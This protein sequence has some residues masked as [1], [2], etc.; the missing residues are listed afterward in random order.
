[1]ADAV[2]NFRGLSVAEAEIADLYAPHFDF[3]QYG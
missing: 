3:A 1:M 2:S